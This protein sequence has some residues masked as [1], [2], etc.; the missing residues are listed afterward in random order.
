MFEQ[1]SAQGLKLF[2]RLR[3]AVAPPDDF[4]HVTHMRAGAG[5]LQQKPISAVQIQIGD[6]LRGQRTYRQTART[7]LTGIAAKRAQNLRDKV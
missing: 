1:P 7:G 5:L 2:T 4:V 3:T 6:V